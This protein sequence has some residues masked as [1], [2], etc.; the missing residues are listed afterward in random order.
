MTAPITGASSATLYSIDVLRLAAG[1][2]A[3]PRLAQPGGT[4]ERRSKTCGSRIVV[5]VVVDDT[6]CVTAYGHHVQAC[7]VGQAAATAVGRAAIGRSANELATLL[8]EMRAFLF[9]ERDAPP[10]IDGI[11]ALIPVRDYPARHDAALLAFDAAAAAAVTA[12]ANAAAPR[13]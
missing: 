7:A 2:V 8:A 9:G 5:D 13:S 10:A 1:T 12:A 11:D 6:G 4:A 3:H